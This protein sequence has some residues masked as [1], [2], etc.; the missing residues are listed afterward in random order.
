MT[1]NTSAQQGS[2]LFIPHGGGPMPLLGDEGH[3]ELIA[4]LK[5]VKNLIKKPSAILMV[6]AHWEEQVA[7]ITS[8]HSPD[9]IY[10]Y[11][12]FPEQAYNIKYPAKGD[13]LLANKV[14]GLLQAQGIKSKLDEHRG[15]DHGMFVPLKLMYPDADIPCVQLSLMSNLDAQTHIDMGK[16]LTDLQNENILI[17][18]SGFSFHNMKEFR[19]KQ[20]NDSKNEAFETWLI[21]TCTNQ[22]I[23]IAQKE[24]ALTQWQK[25]PFARYCQPRE[26]HLLPLHVCFGAGNSNAKLV[27][28]KKV[29]GKK[30]CA[31]LWSS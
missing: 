12:G 13:S 8:N 25:A 20:S 22:A 18:G 3:D 11:Y 27:F 21:D 4:F 19:N 6:S 7:T 24:Q 1:D 16:A 26:E 14:L 29:L 10:D 5:D 15:F 23:T 28:D 9:L 30:T 31:F 2:V 17:I